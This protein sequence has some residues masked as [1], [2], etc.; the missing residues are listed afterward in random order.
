MASVAL[1]EMM[2][3]AREEAAIISS[4]AAMAA[5]ASAATEATA[6]GRAAG[7]EA[8]NPLAIREAAEASA[9]QAVGTTGMSQDGEEGD[10]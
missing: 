4:E 9:R 5:R 8:L 3:V 1:R 6:A 7:H 2:S 10:G